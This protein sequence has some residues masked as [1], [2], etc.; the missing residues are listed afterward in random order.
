[1]SP[2]CNCKLLNS[3][4]SR[5]VGRPRD[6]ESSSPPNPRCDLLGEPYCP[7][8][9]E[10][11]GF[12]GPARWRRTISGSS[13]GAGEWARPSNEPYSLGG[14][15][16]ALSGERA[17]IGGVP[18][19]GGL[20]RPNDSFNAEDSADSP[21]P[22]SDDCGGL[23]L[24]PGSGVC[25]TEG[26]S[27]ASCAGVGIWRT[28]GDPPGRDE[29]TGEPNRAVEVAREKLPATGELCPESR[30]EDG[31]AR[32]REDSG[33]SSAMSFSRALGGQPVPLYMRSYVGSQVRLSSWNNGEDLCGEVWVC[34]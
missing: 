19:R 21:G 34:G 28:A 14:N 2:P 16:G 18:K 27:D 5:D 23:S 25:A 31:T 17:R 9:F 3:S 12:C 8:R 33:A 22:G 13:Y 4:E 11:D 1:M 29:G 32:G 15:L 10:S 30:E 24:L 7:E 26:S 6:G 20:L